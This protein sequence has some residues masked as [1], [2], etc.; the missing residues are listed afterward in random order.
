MSLGDGHDDGGGTR[1]HGLRV[2]CGLVSKRGFLRRRGLRELTWALGGGDG[3]SLGDSSRGG[4]RRGHN[5]LGVAL[6]RRSWL[7]LGVRVGWL[8]VRRLGVR[9]SWLSVGVRWL[10]VRGRLSVR[11]SRFRVGRVRRL[12]I[13]VRWWWWRR[14]NIGRVSRLG[15]R[16][17]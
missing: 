2:N 14:R 5:R 17:S 6:G 3:Q 8:R 13:G 12:R 9:V 15:L 10:R 4:V 11:M 16:V 1:D 7:R